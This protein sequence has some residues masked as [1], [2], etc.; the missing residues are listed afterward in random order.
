MSVRSLEASKTGKNTKS[1]NGGALP[2]SLCFLVPNCFSFS[3]FTPLIHS[4][5][6]K[7]LRK[8]RWSIHSRPTLT[9]L[10]HHLQCNPPHPTLPPPTRTTCPSC[11]QKSCT[12]SSYFSLIP[13][14]TPAELYTPFSASSLSSTSPNTSPARLF[15]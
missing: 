3:T 4:W 7:H 12:Q 13:F 15:R 10:P 1:L 9:H 2:P 11:L 8:Q 6:F 14:T 5:L